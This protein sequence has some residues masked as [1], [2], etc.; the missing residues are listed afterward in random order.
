MRQLRVAGLLLVFGFL[1]WAVACQRQAPDTRAADEQTIH[2]ADIEWSKAAG[3][4]DMEGFLSFWTDDASLLPPNRPIVMGRE[5]IRTHVSQ[6]WADPNFTESWEPT[7]V[8][9]AR[10]G[11]LAYSVGSWDFTI[12]D[13]DGKPVGGRGKY[14]AIWQKQR[15]GSW[16]AVVVIVNSD[17][18]AAAVEK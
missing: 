4:K 17:Q 15:D 10:A 3:A 2:Q 11:D 18:P 8:E 16:K 9:A 12:S 14:V 5:A 7:K 1:A 13:A 6:V